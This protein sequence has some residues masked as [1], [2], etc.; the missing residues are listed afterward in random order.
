MLFLN[1]SVWT[2]TLTLTCCSP[3]TSF[4][5]L[6][7][8]DKLSNINAITW[9][10]LILLSSWYLQLVTWT[11]CVFPTRVNYIWYRIFVTW[12]LIPSLL[13]KP[14]LNYNSTQPQFNITLVVLDKKMTFH[15]T[16]PTHYPPRKI[17]MSNIS[18]VTDPI[19]MTLVQAT[20]VLV[21]FFHIRY[22]STVTDP[23]F[24]KL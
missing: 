4:R 16:P 15:T 21:T 10:L 7:I 14:Q 17:N 24:K 9:S 22:I 18:A 13:S 11:G 1:F 2:L 23:I 20:F 6:K 3:R 19:L 5:S 12:C 8:K